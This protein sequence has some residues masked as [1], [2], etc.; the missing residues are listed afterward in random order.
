KKFRKTRSGNGMKRE[1]ER[2]EWFT[3]AG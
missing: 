1:G 3:L 2:D